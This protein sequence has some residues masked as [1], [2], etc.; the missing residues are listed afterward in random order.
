MA[1]ALRKTLTGLRALGRDHL[2]GAAEIANRAA[3]LLEHYCREERAAAARLP[4]ALAEL[5]ETALRVQPSMAPML[6]LANRIQ[7]AAERSA[8]PLRQLQRELAKLRPA[9]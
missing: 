9:I 4:Y 5:A 2:S 6:N 3:T 1:D 8:K 7:L